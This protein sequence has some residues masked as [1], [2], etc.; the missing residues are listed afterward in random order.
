VATR[1]TYTSGSRTPELDAEFEAELERVRGEVPPPVPHPRCPMAIDD[2][3][4]IDPPLEPKAR[5]QSAAC[6]RV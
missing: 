2:C 1:L 3:R 4:T 5:D 6:I